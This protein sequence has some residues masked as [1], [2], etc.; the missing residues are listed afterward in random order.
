MDEQLPHDVVDVVIVGGGAAG[1]AAALMLAR[2][3]RAVLVIDAGEPRNAPAAHVHGFLTRDGV[4]PTELLALGRA[5]VRRYGAQVH[6]GRATRATRAEDRTFLVELDDGRAVRA[7]RLVVATGLVDELPDI[8]GL[9]A[10]WGRD[11]VHCP[12]CHGWEVQDEATVVIASG[13][14]A[15]HQATLFRQWSA[16]V[17]LCLHSGP[18]P[19]DAERARLEVRGVRIVDGPVA[20]VVVADDRITGVRLA[21]G[22]VLPAG[23]DVVGP[24]M[25]ARSEVLASLGVVAVADPTGTG[26]S[27]PA[28][29]TGATAVPGVWVAGNVADMRGQVLQAAAAGAMTGAAINADLIAEE[30]DRA[31]VAAG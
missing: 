13:P 31:L 25:L 7:R 14:M 24:R 30:T 3:R 11:A 23:A 4:A 19:T 16:D 27:I 15:V 20:E 26:T 22:R 12:Y 10:R 18:V 21:D 2:A 5:E 6:D 9:A 17:T 28:D 1:L 8:A 29:T